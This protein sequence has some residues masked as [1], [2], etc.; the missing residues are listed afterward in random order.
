[1][2]DDL[3]DTRF[4]L[5]NLR[6][7]IQLFVSLDVVSIGIV[8]LS[9]ICNRSKYLHEISGEENMKVF[10]YMSMIGGVFTIVLAFIVLFVMLYEKKLSRDYNLS[11]KKRLNKLLKTYKRC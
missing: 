3:T 7:Q 11:V 6:N 1:M 4:V 5:K 10:T 8:L 2:L 9:W